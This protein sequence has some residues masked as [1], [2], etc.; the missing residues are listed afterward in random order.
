MTTRSWTSRGFVGLSIERSCPGHRP[1]L[2]AISWSLAGLLVALTL[3]ACSAA[4]ATPTPAPLP[5]PTPSGVIIVPGSVEPTPTEMPSQSPAAATTEP[6]QTVSPTMHVKCPSA[7]V[8]GQTLGLLAEQAPT[9]PT[10][11]TTQVAGEAM[12]TCNYSGTFRTMVSF[13]IFSSSPL[14][15]TTE[16]NT[17]AMQ[18]STAVP[19]L[20]DAAYY[21]PDSG[22]DVFVEPVSMLQISCSKG[23]T[24]EQ[25]E[26]LARAV[27]GG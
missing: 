4:T 27:L 6:A 15:A 5:T 10:I 20:G 13:A 3:G 16:A 18:G 23:P 1:G 25:Y 2:R 26:A 22:L 19:G 24:T 8:V 11:M 21:V 12:T 14:L 17:K 7:A 9:S